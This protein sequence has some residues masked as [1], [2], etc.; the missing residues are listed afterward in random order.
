MNTID[1]G[2][3]LHEQVLLFVLLNR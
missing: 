2:N 1:P 3:G